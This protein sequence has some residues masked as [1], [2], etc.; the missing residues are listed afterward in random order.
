M[1]GLWDFLA[2]SSQG[3]G[4]VFVQT[5]TP[6][7]SPPPKPSRAALLLGS[8]LWGWFLIANLSNDLSSV[9]G[10]WEQGVP[11]KQPWGSLRE[12]PAVEGY[13]WILIYSKQVTSVGICNSESILGEE[14][15]GRWVQPK[16]LSPRPCLKWGRVKRPQ[17]CALL[18]VL[19]HLNPAPTA[20]PT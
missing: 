4:P 11:G 14:S 2:V 7:S 10:E 13:V 18:R 9:R 19:L 3:T 8:L 5:I 16:L 17:I 1:Q 15:W 20:S 12:Q 6:S